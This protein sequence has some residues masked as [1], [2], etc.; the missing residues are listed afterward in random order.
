MQDV[1][2]PCGR[3]DSFRDFFYAQETQARSEFMK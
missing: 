3:S 1:G 2:A